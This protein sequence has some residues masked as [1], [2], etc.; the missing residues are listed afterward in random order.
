MQVCD[1]GG[2]QSVSK[3]RAPGRTLKTIVTCELM[4][5]ELCM[6]MELSVL[7]IEALY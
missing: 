2:M 7:H 3:R 6:L 1:T 4:T 5:L